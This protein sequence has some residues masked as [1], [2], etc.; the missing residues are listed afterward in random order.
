MSYVVGDSWWVYAWGLS[1]FV[2]YIPTHLFVIHLSNRKWFSV[3]CT[4]ID[5]SCYC[6]FNSLTL[7]WLAESLQWIFEISA[8]DVITADY[9]VIMSRSLKVTGYHVMYDRSAWILRVIMSS[10]RA[11]CCFPSVKKQRNDFQVCFLQLLIY[12]YLLSHQSFF[13]F[14]TYCLMLKNFC[15]S[16]YVPLICIRFTRWQINYQFHSLSW[17]FFFVRCIIK[18]LL[19][20]VFVISR[21]INVSVRV[22]SL[23]LRLRLITLTLPIIV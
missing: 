4:L 9:T 5:N 8:C 2:G 10:S 17:P 16:N 12:C 7:L 1:P 19:D 13:Q 11:L 14:F 20:S 18:Q 23:S 21:I 22:I 3:V 15:Q 6:T